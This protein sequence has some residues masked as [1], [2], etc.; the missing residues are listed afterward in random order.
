MLS[1]A[2]LGPEGFPVQ[3]ACILARDGLEYGITTLPVP[4]EVP[5]SRSAIVSL[6]F[7]GRRPFCFSS[8][9][10]ADSVGLSGADLADLTNVAQVALAS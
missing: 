2:I 7:P 3:G 8:V 1:S 9:Y 4:E 6:E 5:V 10:L